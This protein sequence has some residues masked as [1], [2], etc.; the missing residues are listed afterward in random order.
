MNYFVFNIY[1][2]IQGALSVNNCIKI[3]VAL[4]AK[5]IPHKV[6]YFCTGRDIDFF[7]EFTIYS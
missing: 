2:T 3:D 5:G 6:T 4:Y 1:F 7:Y